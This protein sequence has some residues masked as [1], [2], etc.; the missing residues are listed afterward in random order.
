MLRW[1]TLYNMVFPCVYLTFEETQKIKPL[2]ENKK[3][4]K[5]Q[6]KTF[7]PENEESQN[8]EI[9]KMRIKSGRII[10]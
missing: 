9:S 4:K 7:I 5:E 8:T 2:Q 1:N 10:Q 6:N 3:I